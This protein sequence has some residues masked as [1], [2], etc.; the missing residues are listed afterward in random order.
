MAA[1]QRSTNAATFHDV[2]REWGS[3]QTTATPGLV[4]KTE[5][6]VADTRPLSGG[7]GA[8]QTAGTVGRPSKESSGA[9]PTS[10]RSL[11]RNVETR[12]EAET[13]TARGKVV[14][15]SYSKTAPVQAEHGIPVLERM[16]AG[17][18]VASDQARLEPTSQTEVEAS[19]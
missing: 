10:A 13:G 12:P 4:R 15:D 9:L 5:G 1:R 3:V 18:W 2:E 7:T 17:A 19:T 6:I 8:A 11:E 14:E 16:A